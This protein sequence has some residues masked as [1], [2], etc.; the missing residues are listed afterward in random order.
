MDVMKERREQK[1]RLPC[2]NPLTPGSG[3]CT[4][5]SWESINEVFESPIPPECKW[6]PAEAT[7]YRVPL[8]SKEQTFLTCPPER[9]HKSLPVFWKSAIRRRAGTSACITTGYEDP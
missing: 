9:P 7:Q 4:E 2:K 8:P 1:N 3:L 6:E 5:A